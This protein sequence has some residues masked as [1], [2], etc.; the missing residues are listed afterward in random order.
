MQETKVVTVGQVPA[1]PVR[2]PQLKN[3]KEN[4]RRNKLKW[5]KKSG[6]QKNWRQKK[7][8]L[9]NKKLLFSNKNYSV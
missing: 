5:K 8:V 3:S 6:M 1:Q 4:K 2:S 9:L 7:K